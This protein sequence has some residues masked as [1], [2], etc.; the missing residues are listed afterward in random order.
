MNDTVV[1]TLLQICTVSVTMALLCYFAIT[2]L[3]K[4]F[5]RSNVKHP[6]PPGPPREPLIGAMRNFPK[7]HFSERFNDWAKKYGAPYVA[8]LNFCS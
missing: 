1:S 4:V 3:P 8:N 5:P 6:Y 2:G 7:D